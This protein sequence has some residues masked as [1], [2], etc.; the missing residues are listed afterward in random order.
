M[1]DGVDQKRTYL[2]IVSALRFRCGWWIET[3]AVSELDFMQLTAN[4]GEFRYKLE[5][6]GNKSASAMVTRN[7]LFVGLCWMRLAMEHLEDAHNCLLMGRRR[8]VYSRAYYAA[9]NASKCVRYFVFGKV[10][11]RGDDHHLASELPDDFPNVEKWAEEIPKLYEHRL[12]ADYDNWQTTASEFT[13]SP[14][15]A[16]ELASEF[17]ERSRAYLSRRIGTPI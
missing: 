11:L 15:Q 4:H 5:L 12:H 2:R 10:S 14:E 7:A 8:A 16:F 3:P 9:Y 1:S 17:V 6:L 13:L